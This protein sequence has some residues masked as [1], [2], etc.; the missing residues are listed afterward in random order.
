MYQSKSSLYTFA[1]LNNIILK[2]EGQDH[3]DQHSYLQDMTK[4]MDSSYIQLILQG[5]MLD[6]KL[7]LLEQIM[8]LLI[9]S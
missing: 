5:I 2:L 7:L 4:I 3:L 8:L 1:T 6:G 9:P